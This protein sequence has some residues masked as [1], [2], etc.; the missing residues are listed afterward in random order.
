MHL[1]REVL[2]KKLVSVFALAAL[3]APLSAQAD[4]KSPDCLATPVKLGFN[5]NGDVMIIPVVDDSPA[6]VSCQSVKDTVGPVKSI[7]ATVA[8]A[9]ALVVLNPKIASIMGRLKQ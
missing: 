9:S 4:E 1:T 5:E 8:A 3:L 2:M 7:K 6:D